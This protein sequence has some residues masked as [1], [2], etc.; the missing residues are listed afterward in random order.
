MCIRDSNNVDAG[1]IVR[2]SANNKTVVAKVL[3]PL[4][5]I[6]EDNGLTFRI[7]NAAASALGLADTKFNAVVSY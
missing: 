4:P 5:D 3:G 2:I 6:K 7:S 1:T